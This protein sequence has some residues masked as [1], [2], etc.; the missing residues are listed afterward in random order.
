MNIWKKIVKDLCEQYP[1]CVHSGVV[2]LGELLS[3]L[4]K[5][6]AKL[7]EETARMKLMRQMAPTAEISDIEFLENIMDAMY[8]E[9]EPDYMIPLPALK[10]T[11][12]IIQETLDEVNKIHAAP[13][14]RITVV[15]A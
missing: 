11:T 14:N 3:H 9:D 13:K 7:E 8:K 6:N 10:E 1:Q 15:L 2:D 12:R 4:Q 5:E